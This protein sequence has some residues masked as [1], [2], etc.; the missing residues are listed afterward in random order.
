MHDFDLVERGVLGEHELPIYAAAVIHKGDYPI[1]M[2]R[3]LNELTFSC[4]KSSCIELNR[5]HSS[6]FLR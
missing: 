4:V 2:E 3:C 1:I 5:L 6:S